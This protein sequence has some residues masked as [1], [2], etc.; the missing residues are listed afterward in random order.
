[1]AAPF[2][3]TRHP[4]IYKRGSRYVVRYRAGGK[5]RSE[6]TRTLEEALRLKRSREADRDR[7]EFQAQS[8]VPFRDYAEEWIDR[9]QGNG[10]RG[11]TE[12]TRAD[13]RRDL[14]RYVYP[15]FDER[16]A[17]SQITPRDVANWIGWLC[18]EHLQG[19]R[20]ADATIRRITSPLRACLATAKREGLIRHNP[21]DGAALPHR[22]R[23]E[24]H[25][26][27]H[28]R[29][30]TREQLGTFLGIVN[31]A[32]RLMFRFLAVT[33]LRWS[34]LAA[35]RWQDLHL[36]GSNP[37]VEVRRAFVR[38]TFKPPKSRYGKRAVPLNAGLVF[39]LR[40]R[41]DASEWSRGDGV[42][43]P[44]RNGQPLRQENVRRRVLKPA[45]EEAGVPWAGF[46]TFRHTCASLLFARGKNAKQ[47]QRWLGH[48]AAS[49][50]LDTY[51]HL[52][53]DGLGTALDLE[54]E[55]PSRKQGVLGDLNSAGDGAELI[56]DLPVNQDGRNLEV[57]CDPLDVRLARMASAIAKNFADSD[58][59]RQ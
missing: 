9:Y 24:D 30:L 52:L 1:M 48:H 47:V 26:T 6:S 16:L 33:G 21:V 35:L 8:R 45:A 41:R 18:D 27:E 29:A 36:N 12:H 10:R 38:G 43:F 54:Q 3:P 40:T 50:T 11:F 7:G 46:H 57:A 25:E 22:E 20:L 2:E 51:T 55:L 4:G 34:E 32:Y 53:D 37:R 15:F 14:K 31:P 59:G 58:C 19:R 49:F 13:Y 42:V 5:Q 56:L 28:V 17:V 39:E 23:I 44:A